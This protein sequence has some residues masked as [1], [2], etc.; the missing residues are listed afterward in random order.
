MAAMRGRWWVVALVAALTVPLAVPLLGRM[1]GAEPARPRRAANV[2]SAE[3]A[4]AARA[5]RASGR[6]VEVVG[7]RGIVS[8]TFANPDGSF[9][10]TI[11]LTPVRV[12]RG[13]GWVPV[14]LTL[15]EGPDGRVAP[16]A[17]PTQVVLS[18]GGT[19]PF[20]SLV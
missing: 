14:D 7:R 3:E 10:D 15:R 11:H 18:G 9:T 8:E 19:G 4:E 2:A 20:A 17:S 6:R 1:S 16:V 5:A 13:S 12:R